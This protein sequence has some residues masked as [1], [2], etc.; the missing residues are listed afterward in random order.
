M[1]SGQTIMVD[2]Q[3]A[4]RYTGL[5]YAYKTGFPFLWFAVLWALLRPVKHHIKTNLHLTVS[6]EFHDTSSQ[7]KVRR[8]GVFFISSNVHSSDP[9]WDNRSCSDEFVSSH[10]QSKHEERYQSYLLP[11]KGISTEMK[12]PAD[13]GIKA[14]GPP[15][16]GTPEAKTVVRIWT[17]LT[18]CHW[19]GEVKRPCWPWKRVTTETAW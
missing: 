1:L 10:R 13:G 18:N 5:Q 14:A 16:G 3:R 2:F 12:H 15:T 9:L 11:L 6:G 4:V 19:S 17:T 7:S 8:D